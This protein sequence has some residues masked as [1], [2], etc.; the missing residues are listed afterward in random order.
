LFFYCHTLHDVFV[1]P[2]QHVHLDARL[3]RQSVGN[4]NADQRDGQSSSPALA[5]RRTRRASTLTRSRGDSTTLTSHQRRSSVQT[6]AQQQE[7]HPHQADSP[8]CLCTA[9]HLRVAV[10]PRRRDGIILLPF[11]WEPPSDSADEV[12]RDA[13][14]LPGEM[15]HH[16]H[17]IAEATRN[18]DCKSFHLRYHSLWLVLTKSG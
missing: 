8:N 1:R 7:A 3:S 16:V 10:F 14:Q 18:V 11:P 2:L 12:S 13:P 6:P 15:V 9:C 17:R 5:S 4:M